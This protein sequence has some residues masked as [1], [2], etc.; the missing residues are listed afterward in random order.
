[1]NYNF[2]IILLAAFSSLLVGFVWYNPK[3]FGTIWMRETKV[4]MD[5]TEK[6]GMFKLLILHFIYSIFVAVTL[7]PIVIHQMGAM[8]MVGGPMM[9]EKTLP[10]Y[11]NFMNDYGTAF[12]TFKHGALHGFL[13]GLFF[14]FPLVGITSLYEKR[15]F[16]YVLIT[17]GYWIVSLMIMGAI[18]CKWF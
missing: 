13:T 5:G 6:K 18:I 10:S 15:S 4:E 11:T 17:A 1:M 2:P 9:A 16:K 7:H 3:V 8:S 14:V 12:R